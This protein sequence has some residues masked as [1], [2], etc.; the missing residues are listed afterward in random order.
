[1]ATL[2]SGASLHSSVTG[3]DHIFVVGKSTSRWF[4]NAQH[5]TALLSDAVP[6]VKS[7]VFP[8]KDEAWKDFYLST[9]RQLGFRPAD[10]DVVVYTSS[11]R[12][13][14]DEEALL[15][16]IQA[17]YGI[18]L[19]A[20][21]PNEALFSKYAAQNSNVV[22]RAASL[23]EIEQKK[24]EETKVRNTALKDAKD[25]AELCLKI[26]QEVY[27]HLCSFSYRDV[28]SS[29]QRLVLPTVKRAALELGNLETLREADLAAHA[30]AMSES[31]D[32][33][34]FK[35]NKTQIPKSAFFEYFAGLEGLLSASFDVARASILATDLGT[36]LTLAFV[37]SDVPDLAALT[38]FLSE[39]VS[40]RH[41][42]LRLCAQFTASSGSQLNVVLLKQDAEASISELSKVID[43]YYAAQSAQEKVNQVVME[44]ITSLAKALPPASIESE[45]ER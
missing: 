45:S 2:I 23:L 44:R 35:P 8:V 29:I 33:A 36:T 5:L 14:G 24:A 6:A 30:K 11:G 26:S 16:Y 4:V 32:T 17:K 10:H 41:R 27:S 31:E 37:G 40:F 13:I 20:L 21:L 9:A 39:F 18:D 19:R 38:M 15:A 43:S 22:R 25:S 3:A 28:E 34:S 12:F 42:L 1:M 7:S